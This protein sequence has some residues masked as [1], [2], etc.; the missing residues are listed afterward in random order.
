MK[1]I[2]CGLLLTAFANPVLADGDFNFYFT[3]IELAEDLD[4]NDITGP[5]I[6]VRTWIGQDRPML[7]LEYQDARPDVERFGVQFENEIR[8]YRTGIGYRFVDGP[9]GSFWARAEYINYKFTEENVFTTISATDTQDGYGLHLGGRLI[10]NALSV[11]LEGGY[12]HLSDL[13]G[14]EGT[15]GVNYQPSN[16]GGFLEFRKSRLETDGP[17]N[18]D[19]NLNDIRV[20]LRV[21][22]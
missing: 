18:I 1:N 22:F 14:Y 19:I 7:T 8:S 5:S 9:S 10:S 2:I 3:Q 13:I 4:P 15:V 12:V 11:Y 6:G 17:T 16:V 21:T 20:G